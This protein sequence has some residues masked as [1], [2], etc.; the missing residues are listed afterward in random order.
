MMISIAVSA[1]RVFTLPAD[2]P[3]TRAQFR[4]FRQTLQYL[5]DLRLV[6]TYAP[7]QYRILYSAA[8]ARVYRVDLY[9]D[10]QARFDEA[11][12]TFYVT[13]L[14]GIPAVASKATL[15]S[16]TGQGDYSS[17]LILRSAGPRTDAK[18]DVRISAT[19]AKPVGLKLIPNPAVSL[20]VER[21]VRRRI[22]EITDVFIRRS[23]E[24]LQP[25]H[26]SPA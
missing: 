25:Q 8:H 21:V 15:G 2:L 5:P 12:D 16:L 18:Y 14:K 19:L 10:I 26:R 22:Q 11:E 23:I 7:E 24:A 1:R 20:F 13:P 4:D 9:S 3:T 17:R 6:K